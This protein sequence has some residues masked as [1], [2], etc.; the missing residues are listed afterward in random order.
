[1][2]EFSEMGGGGGLFLTKCRQKMNLKKM[3]KKT[4]VPYIPRNVTNNNISGS[5]TPVD[6]T[7]AKVSV[8]CQMRF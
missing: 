6:S 1:M 4:G 7:T 3:K 5:L 8:F 2:T